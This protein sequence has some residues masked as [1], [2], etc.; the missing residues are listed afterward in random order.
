MGDYSKESIKVF[1]EHQTQLF[2]E[3][4]ANTVREARDWLT[5]NMAV[6]VDNLEEVKKYFE[7]NGSDISGMSDEEILSQSEVFALPSGRFL[8]VEG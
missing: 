8:I 7:Q 3:V 2:G 4:V 1:L 6:E 5:E